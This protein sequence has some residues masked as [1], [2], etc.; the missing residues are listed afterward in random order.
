MIQAITIT[1]ALHLTKTVWQALAVI[2]ILTAGSLFVV[3]L[4]IMNM[5]FGIG[6]TIVLILFNIITTAFPM[7][8]RAARNLLQ[9]QGGYL[10]IGLLVLLGFGEIV[11]WIAFCHAYYPIKTINTTLSSRDKPVIVPIGLNAGAMM[12]Y[13]IGMALLML[14]TLLGNLLGPH[15]IFANI[16]FDA[17][18]SGL[19]AFLLFYFFMFMTFNPKEQAK[20]L[21]NSNN[22]IL[23]IRPGEPTR[24]Y[25][26][27]KL[28]VI[29]FPGALLNSIQLTL[30]LLG[31]PLLGKYAGF[32]IIPMYAV[33][34]VMFMIGIRDALMI[35]L[36]PKKYQQ[37]EETY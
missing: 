20:Q 16:Y 23:G 33:M 24:Q 18:I 17:V 25:I 37:L 35:L 30:G 27:Q 14:P 34:I 4:G 2:I 8:I 26:K 3:W 19:L 31:I 22:Y 36:F 11:F 6:G 5:K 28:L 9:L 21:R 13:M 12:T 15:S 10:W 7:I 32:A 29:S 1:F